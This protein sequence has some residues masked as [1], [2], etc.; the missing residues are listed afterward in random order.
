M[1]VNNVIVVELMIAHG[2]IRAVIRWRVGLK[3]KPTV[4]VDNVVTKTAK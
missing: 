1:M 3:E 2:M 4:P